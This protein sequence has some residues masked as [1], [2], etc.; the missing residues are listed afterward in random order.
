MTQIRAIRKDDALGF[1]AVLDAVSQERKFLA[2]FDAPPEDR[3]RAFVESNVESGHPQFVAEE[4]GRIV[5]WCDALPG[6]VSAGTAHIGH[7]G[8]GV[9]KSRRG[10]GI[11]RR[12]IQATIAGARAVGLE[13]IELSVYSSNEPAIAL[14]RSFGFREEGKRLRGRLVDGI[15][16]DVFLM[17]LD[18]RVPNQSPGPAVASSTP[19]AEHESR[20][21]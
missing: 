12:L 21:R 4:E 9:L 18:I 16:D 1:R 2:R 3:V 17:A 8:M 7:L 19:H 14:Y 20:N 6:T 15:Y 5:G 10:N 11:G 13:K